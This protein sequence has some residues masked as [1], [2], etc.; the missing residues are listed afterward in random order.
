MVIYKATVHY[1]EHYLRGQT[2]MGTKITKDPSGK[3]L[4][5]Y[6]DQSEE[7]EWVFIDKDTIEEIEVSE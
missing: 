6:K 7:P 2:V 3:I 5:L 4:L 1:Y